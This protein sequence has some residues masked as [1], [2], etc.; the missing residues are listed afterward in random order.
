MVGTITFYDDEGER[1]DTIYVANAPES[2]KATFFEK[3]DTELERIKETYPE[4][5]YVGIA[6]GAHELWTWLEPR[7]TWQIVDF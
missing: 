6:D 4:A 7:T 2:G 1:I 5:R 3:M